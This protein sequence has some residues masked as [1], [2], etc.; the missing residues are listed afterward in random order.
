MPSPSLTVAIPRSTRSRLSRQRSRNE[1]LG[2]KGENFGDARPRTEQDK[3]KGV[4]ANARPGTPIWLS[5]DLPNM[6]CFQ[7]SLQSHWHSK[8]PPACA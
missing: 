4:V 3:Q 5:E 2:G 6:L 7:V 8:G 1:I